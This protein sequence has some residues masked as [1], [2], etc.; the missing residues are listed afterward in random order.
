MHG[1]GISLVSLGQSLH[2]GKDA[3]DAARRVEPSRGRLEPREFPESC[4]VRLEQFP[5]G[6][7]GPSATPWQPTRGSD[8]AVA[9]TKRQSLQPTPGAQ[10]RQRRRPEK[11]ETEE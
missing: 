1:A 9:K 7:H 3:E 2:A 8:G 4:H 10:R 5:S 11:R 6:M